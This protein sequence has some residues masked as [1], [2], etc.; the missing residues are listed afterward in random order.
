MLKLCSATSIYL[1]FEFPNFSSG[2]KKEKLD[3]ILKS[4]LYEMSVLAQGRQN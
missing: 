4:K 3:H 1:T 2:E